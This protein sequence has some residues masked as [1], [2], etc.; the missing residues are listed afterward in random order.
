M[1]QPA[2]RALCGSGAVFFVGN[3]MHTMAVSWLM[4]QITH[5]SFLVALVQTAAFLPMF[6]LS[7]PGG[8]L[9]DTADRRALLLGSLW[10]YA[11]A[12]A[13]LTLL[14]AFGQAGPSTLLLFCFL[15][16]GCTALL[17]PAWNSA[18]GD[19]IV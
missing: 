6:L 7:L 14:A 9:A 3:A 4:V 12:A 16:G 10:T 19:T 15:M 1:R 17:S 11:A 8:V 13:L 2:F 18:V 5:S